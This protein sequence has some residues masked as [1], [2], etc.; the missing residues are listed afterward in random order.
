MKEKHVDCRGYYDRMADLFY[1]GSLYNICERLWK[2]CRKEFRYDI[3]TVDNQYVSTPM[4]ML[5]RGHNDCKGYSLFI[6]GVLDAMKRQGEDIKWVYRFASYRLFNSQPGH[7]FVVVNPKTDNIWIDPVLDQFDEHYPYIYHRDVKISG[8]SGIFG[9]QP[10]QVAGICCGSSRSVGA[11]YP[12]ASS[13]YFT[14]G[15]QVFAHDQSVRSNGL[16][17]DQMGLPYAMLLMNKGN[18][19]YDGRHPGSAQAWW[20]NPPVTF[21]L[22]GQPFPLPLANQSP[23]SS[24]QLMPLGIEVRYAPSFLDFNIPPG[25]MRPVVAQGAGGGYQNKLRMS[26][27]LYPIDTQLSS[28]DSLPLIV[29]EGA[30]GPL[31]NAYSSY[32]YANAFSSTNNIDGKMFNHRNADD[33]LQPSI[34]S[35]VLQTVEPLV[36]VLVTTLVPGVG[37]EIATAINAAAGKSGGKTL[38]TVAPSSV[39]PSLSSFLVNADGSMNMLPLVAI[40]GVVLLLAI[41]KK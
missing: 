22:N 40:G 33:L 28:L 19:G 3:E 32:P 37:S 30:V 25:F 7:V 39:S 4:T 8:L 36:D 9:V 15:G 10:A 20:N 14:Q 41:S 27:D 2:F 29:L 12:A 34:S 38:S 13:Y 31:I 17:A 23:G 16:T 6:G 21:W 5:K 1:G 18:P 26:P 11:V 24:T 35:T